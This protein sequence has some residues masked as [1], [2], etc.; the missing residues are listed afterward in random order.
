MMVLFQRSIKE[1]ITKLSNQFLEGSKKI[2][3][4]VIFAGEITIRPHY[5]VNSSN[6]KTTFANILE[7]HLYPVILVFIEYLTLST[8]L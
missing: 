8:L 5:M 2:W 6:A 4:S 7:N 3:I 1:Y